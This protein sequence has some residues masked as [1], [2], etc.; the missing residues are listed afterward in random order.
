MSPYKLLF[1]AEAFSSM[2]QHV[3]AHEQ[4]KG[5]AVTRSA[6]RVSHLLFT[7]DTIIF[8]QATME[9]MQVIQNILTAYAKASGQVINL[10]KSSMVI[11]RNV[12]DPCQTQFAQI[13]GVQI[14]SKHGKI[15][16]I[17]GGYWQVEKGVVPRSMGSS[18]DENANVE[19]EIAITGRQGSINQVNFAV[20]SHIHHVM[21]Q[22]P[23]HGGTRM[24]QGGRGDMTN[25]S[26]YRWLLASLK[27][28]CSKEY[29]I[30]FG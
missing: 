4:I 22:A 16:R 27:W 15:L 3:E 21:L 13:L 14:V 17:T 25:T 9:V 8:C 6:P 2:L 18:L 26:D 28:S 11:N 12:T 19:F 20:D 24:R 29:G 10:D 1:I 5:I 23:E 30:K 7:D